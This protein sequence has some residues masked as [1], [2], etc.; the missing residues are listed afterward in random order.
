MN[1]FSSALLYYDP[2]HLGQ[3]AFKDTTSGNYIPFYLIPNLTIQEQFAPLIGFDITTTDQT[4]LRFEYA[5]SRQLSLSLYDYQ[6]SEVR[7]SSITFGG[8]YR[9]KGVNMPFKIP[10]VKADPSQTDLNISLDLGFRN[11]LQ[12]NSQ[13]DQPNAYSTGGQKTITIQP[14]IDYLINNRIDLKFYFDQQRTI[15]YISTSAP[16]IN[17]RAGIEL[18]ISIA[19]SNQSPQQ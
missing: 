13:L 16:I 9:K 1:S 14:S 3:P 5:K 12:T 11:D 15:P 17:T 4:A 7:S 19:P 10:F 6:L 8:T 2:L 18:R